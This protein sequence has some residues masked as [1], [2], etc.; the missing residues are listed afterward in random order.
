MEKRRK[1]RY[2]ISCDVLCSTNTNPAE[3]LRAKGLNI[4]LRGIKLALNQLINDK[5]ITLKIFDPRS[6]LPIIANGR[7]VWQMQSV[8]KDTVLAGIEF[9]KTSWA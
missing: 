3:E 8:K 9:T 4:S 7:L 1:R 5:N 2:D 6:N